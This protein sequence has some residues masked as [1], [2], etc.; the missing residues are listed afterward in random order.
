LGAR[1]GVGLAR[2]LTPSSVEGGRVGALHSVRIVVLLTA[3]AAGDCANR[4]MHSHGYAKAID[5]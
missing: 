4:V 3:D 5:A 1:S 2:P